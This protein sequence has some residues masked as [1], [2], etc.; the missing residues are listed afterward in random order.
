M[1]L[2]VVGRRRTSLPGVSLRVALIVEFDKVKYV[3]L[4]IV[5]FHAQLKCSERILRSF[6]EVR[7]TRKRR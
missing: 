4:F 1:S 7:S 3:P 6:P 2:E 5:P